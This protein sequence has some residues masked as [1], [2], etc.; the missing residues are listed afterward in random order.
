MDNNKKTV[1][2][3][4][5]DAQISVFTGLIN[6][7]RLIWLLFQD[8]RVSMLAK[9]VI[10]ISLLYTISPVDFI[11]DV[12]LGLGQLDDLGVILLG[13]ALFIK[14]APPDV[15]EYYQNL[16]EYG[17]DTSTQPAPAEDDETIDTTYHVL[18]DE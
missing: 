8:S 10:P 17:E 1:V 3:V 16:I 11:P 14:L 6:K 15:V 13:V 18:D 7:L 4:N 5:P 2:S 12:I 9:S